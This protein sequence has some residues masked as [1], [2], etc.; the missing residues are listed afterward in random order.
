METE[1]ESMVTVP[2]Q[3]VSS[4]VPLLILQSSIFHL[5]NQYLLHVKNHSLQQSIIMAI[6]QISSGPMPS[7][8][9]PGYINSGLVQISV[10]PTPYVP[11]SKKDYEILL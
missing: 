8:M 7:L 6:V 11:P 9:T 3:Q 4:S 5:L 1:V 2:I 10:S